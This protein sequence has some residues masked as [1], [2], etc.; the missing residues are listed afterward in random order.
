[1]WTCGYVDM[2]MRGRVAG[3]VGLWSCAGIV[4]GGHV[5]VWDLWTFEVSGW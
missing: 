4:R 5:V 1:M 2:W 3:H